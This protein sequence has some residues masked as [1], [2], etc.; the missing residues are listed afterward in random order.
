MLRTRIIT[1]V[2][3]LLELEL[4][5]LEARAGCH[6]RLAGEAAVVHGIGAVGGD[7]DVPDLTALSRRAQLDQETVKNVQSMSAEDRQAMIGNMIAQL[8]ARLRDNP[9]DVAGLQRL[10]RSYCVVGKKP[11]AEDAVKR[12][13]DAFASDETKH[14][15]IVE[16]AAALGLSSGGTITSMGGRVPPGRNTPTPCARS[17]WC[18]S[19]HGETRVSV[20]SWQWPSPCVTLS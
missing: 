8:D 14:G 7:L 13:L 6:G 18:A 10:I 2:V 3:A 12:A 20:R 4:E 15:Q 1:A 19:A 11:A 17:H 16:F 9:D 5:R